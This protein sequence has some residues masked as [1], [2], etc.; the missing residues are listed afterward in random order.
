[1]MRLSHAALGAACALTVGLTAYAGMSAS[2][3]PAAS[4]LA[5]GAV[6]PK[7]AAT[8]AWRD[9]PTGSTARFRGLAVVSRDVVWVAGYD[10]T[11]LRTVDGGATWSSVGPAAAAGLQ[12]RDIEA[13][14]A[15]HAVA[16]TVGSG[17]E[18]RIYVTDDGGASWV[19]A[20]RMADPA[21]F[22]DCMAFTD[23]LRGVVLSDPV[24]GVLTLKATTDG[25]HTWRSVDTSRAPAPLATEYYFAGSGTCLSAGVG[26]RLAIGTGGA[27]RARV[28][29]SDDRGASWS[30]VDTPVAASGSAGIFSVRF[31]DA[32]RGVIVGGDYLAPD[33]R[34]A[35]AAWTAD[36]GRTWSLPDVAP[37]GYR[38]GSA[39]AAVGG[40]NAGV[41]AIAVGPTGSD[42]SWDCGRTWRPIDGS[43]LDTVQCV[44][45][46]CYASGA[47]GRVAVLEVGSR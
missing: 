11:I 44:A 39:Y 33:S 16:M 19:E 21:G 37:G 18:S 30:V 6:A 5:V 28:F 42:V 15:S 35:I 34:D 46:R 38:S 43:S 24:G 2:A 31:M 27:D 1:M 45:G 36:G 17:E 4:S 40:P 10:G 23:R 25:G 3:A 13:T 7:P 29:L 26:G 32:R 20:D 12:F 8:L 9:L 22:Y 47:G 14:S 41:A